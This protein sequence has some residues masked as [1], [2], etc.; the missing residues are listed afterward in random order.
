V[1]PA[2]E[3]LSFRKT[4]T[5]PASRSALTARLSSRPPL[6]PMSPL[7]HRG[8]LAVCSSSPGAMVLNSPMRRWVALADPGQ[9]H[10]VR[11][12]PHVLGHRIDTF[13]PQGSLV[14]QR[15]LPLNGLSRGKGF[16]RISQQRGLLVYPPL[17]SILLLLVSWAFGRTICKTP[18]F[19]SASALSARTSVGRR[20]DR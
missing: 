14:S 8:I 1:K 20:T 6:R 18:F 13:K 4:S 17:T 12:S 3:G 16:I 9:Q 19:N 2:S 7:I 10:H 5:Y 11:G 15:N